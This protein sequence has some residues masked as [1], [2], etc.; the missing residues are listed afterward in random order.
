[1]ADAD[2]ETARDQSPAADGSGF[3]FDGTQGRGRTLGSSQP[4]GECGEPFHEHDKERVYEDRPAGRYG[5]KYIC[6]V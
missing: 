1:M 2:A 4:C 5:Y 3:S 6:P